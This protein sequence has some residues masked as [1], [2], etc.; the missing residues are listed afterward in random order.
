M[1]QQGDSRNAGEV[2]AVIIAGLRFRSGGCGP[3]PGSV[4]RPILG[5][6]PPRWPENALWDTASGLSVLGGSAGPSAS[7][8]SAPV[9]SSLRVDF[10]G[11]LCPYSHSCPLVGLHGFLFTTG[12]TACYKG[13]GVRVRGPAR[14][15]VSCRDMLPC[16]DRGEGSTAAVG[17]ALGTTPGARAAV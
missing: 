11:S 1:E 8:A 4:C 12:G 2:L 15:P 17:G 7:R 16:K 5:P 10:K 13:A 14:T 9:A 3:L 6:S